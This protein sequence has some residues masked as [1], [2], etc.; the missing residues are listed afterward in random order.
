[1]IFLREY[2]YDNYGKIWLVEITNRG[3]GVW[4]GSKIVEALTSVNTSQLLL[5]HF[6]NSRSSLN[7]K[8]RKKFVYL[9]YIVSPKKIIQKISGDENWHSEKEYLAHKIWQKLPAKIQ[10]VQNAVDR[11]GVLIMAGNTKETLISK[12]IKLINS[13]EFS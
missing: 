13:L 6:A 1:M 10:T 12:S 8:L 5:T 4:I 9:R 3:G 7:I 2:I 11:S